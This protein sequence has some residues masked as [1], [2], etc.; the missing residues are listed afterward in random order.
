MQPDSPYAVPWWYR[1]GFTLP[2]TFKGKT[3]WLQ[4]RGINY[5][6]NIWLNGKQIAK[7]E[8]VAG[9]WR[10]YEFNTTDAA[11]P[12]AENALAVQVWAPKKDDLAITFVDWNPAPPDKNMGLWR[13]V[14][15]VTSGPVALRHPAVVSKID[16]PANDKAHLT[17]TAQLRNGT[18]QPVRGTLQG[19]FENVEISQEVQLGPGETKDVVFTPDPRDR[20]RID[21]TRPACFY[22]QWEEDPDS[23]RWIFAGHDAAREPSEAG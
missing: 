14:D 2:A 15:M 10:T 16:S 21:R 5:R 7:D 22:D 3:I 6:A 17:V 13:G 18:N 11:K 20:F 19:K 12:G 1:K 23:R 8:D 4:F 9:A